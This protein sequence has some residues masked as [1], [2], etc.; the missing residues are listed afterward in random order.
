MVEM[1]RV[2]TRPVEPADEERLAHMWA[3]L[4]RETLYQRFHASVGSY[5]QSSVHQ[6]AETDHR[7]L[8]AIVALVDDEIVG[9]VRYQR[10]RADP[11]RAEFAMLVEDAW[12]G[13]GLGGRLLDELMALARSRGVTTLIASLL[14]DNQRML[15]LVRRHAPDALIRHP[16]ASTR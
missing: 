5:P 16:T 9:F 3:R 14:M 13:A 2:T 4:S 12:Q 8:D 7:E 10:E 11:A 15:R 6:L 1:E